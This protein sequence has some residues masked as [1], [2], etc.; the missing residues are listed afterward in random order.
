MEQRPTLIINFDGASTRNS[1]CSGGVGVAVYNTTTT[2]TPQLVVKLSQYLG[3]NKTNNQAE[4]AALLASIRIAIRLQ[5]AHVTLVSDSKLLV[6]QMYNRCVT[7]DEVLGSLRRSC[8]SLLATEFGKDRWTLKHVT[9]DYNKEADKL[10]KEGSVKHLD[11]MC[12]WIQPGI[13]VEVANHLECPLALAE[14][15]PSTSSYSQKALQRPIDANRYKRLLKYSIPMVSSQAAWLISGSCTGS[16]LWLQPRIPRDPTICLSD[17]EFCH[18]LRLRLLL[19]QSNTTLLGTCVQC[20][21]GDAALV[22]GI[23]DHH[24]LDCRLSSGMRNIRHN[25]VVDAVYNFLCQCFPEATTIKEYPIP[26]AANRG[27]IVDVCLIAGPATYYIDVSIVNPGATVYRNY[28]SAE[29]AGVAAK[30]RASDKKSLY[31]RQNT[32]NV[33]IIPFIIEAGGRWGVEASSFIQATCGVKIGST[34]ASD[35]LRAR[36][37]ALRRRINAIL[38]KSNSALYCR[39]FDRIQPLVEQTPWVAPEQSP[40]VTQYVS[41]RTSDHLKFIPR[42]QR[43]KLQRFAEVYHLPSKWSENRPI[44]KSWGVGCMKCSQAWDDICKSCS[45]YLCFSCLN[46]ANEHPCIGAIQDF[47]P[48]AG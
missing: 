7:S 11:R 46:N 48:A 2:E 20:I 6:D 4:Y 13:W 30:K 24:A 35:D 25:Q 19:P 38:A 1:G 5:A 47:A 14:G 41:S 37:K 39:S 21:C 12:V 27:S 9:R 17:K 45:H 26:G 29:Y 43:D 22:A 42:K 33:T 34:L 44:V 31:R 23:D 36:K 32:R 28:G 10:S 40:L 3:D 18:N 8:Q 16:A 15:S